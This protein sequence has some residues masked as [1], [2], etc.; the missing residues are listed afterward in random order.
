MKKM[1]KGVTIA[2]A[3]V[4][5][6]TTLGPT[7]NTVRAEMSS[8]EVIVFEKE[9]NSSSIMIDEEGVEINGTYYTEEE[10]TVLLLQAEPV[11]YQDNSGD[12]VQVMFA[13][14]PGIYFIPGIGQVA[15]AATGAIV[16][17]GVTITAGNWMYKT[18]VNFLNDPRRVVSS[19]YDIPTSLLNSNGRVRLGNFKDKHGNTPLKK[20]SGTFNNGRWSIKKDTASHGGR[21]WKL[22]KDG[23]RKAS[24]DKN[25]KVLSK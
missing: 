11:N 20:S 1:I 16:V 5:L 25:G 12:E 14:A 6:F 22:Y 18:I 3:T 19:K 10:F 2:F 9:D 23:K 4:T 8:N 7:M 17:A 21:R 24:L 15:L 13:A